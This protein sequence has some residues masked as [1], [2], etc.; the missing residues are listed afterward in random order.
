MSDFR[1]LSEDP[2]NAEPPITTLSTSLLTPQDRVFNRN[3]GPI[4]SKDVE[5][6][7]LSIKSE[8]PE[9]S[10]EKTLNYSDLEKFHSDEVICALSCAG[11]RRIE[12]DQEKKVEGLLWGGSAIANSKF[13]GPLLR[14]VL[15]SYGVT[16]DKVEENRHIHFETTQKC[17]D[18]DFYGSS[19]PLSLALDPERPVMLATHMNDEPLDE[20]HGK[21]CRLVVP[22]IIGARSVKWLERIII[23]DKP[24][25]NF[26]MTRDY[27]VLPPEATS[28]TKEEYL[29]QVEPLME[30]PLNSEICEPA[31]GNSIKLSGGERTVD[32]RGYALGTKG[33]PIESVKVCAVPLPLP[34][35]ATDS[36]DDLPHPE[37]HQIR[38]FARSLAEERWIRA[39]LVDSVEGESRKETDKN[40]SWTLFSSKVEIPDECVAKAGETQVALVAFATDKNGQ[41]QELQT[42]YNLR[43]VAE[44][45]WSVARI[46][47]E[48]SA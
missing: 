20:K 46:K 12:M 24:S 23:R 39:K 41:E 35:S 27:K 5:T 16:L 17:E 36:E 28:E 48:N 8:V 25:D 18:A 26:Y 2:L 43:G 37:L 10:L 29:K 40:W 9:V 21:P 7:T 11:N 44:A 32:V 38:L 15:E 13:S 47:L 45:S 33:T 31:D 30:L 3:H 22:G 4:L 42:P 14:H 6:Y 1:V 19:L 34:P